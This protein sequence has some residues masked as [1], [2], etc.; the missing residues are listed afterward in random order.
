MYL[1]CN[2]SHLLCY[3]LKEV[4]IGISFFLLH[5]HS[6]K[7]THTYHRESHEPYVRARATAIASAST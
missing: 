6:D 5:P 7:V 4:W 3:Y 1:C 2:F